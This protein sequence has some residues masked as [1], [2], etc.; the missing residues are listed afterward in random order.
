MSGC[1]PSEEN[2]RANCTC[3]CH[4]KKEDWNGTACCKCHVHKFYAHTDILKEEYKN[5]QLLLENIDILKNELRD[6]K[7]VYLE[8]HV[9]QIDENR[10]ISRRVD[11]LQS[12]INIEEIKKVIFNGL[13]THAS[14]LRCEARNK[15]L[16]KEINEISK[17]RKDIKILTDQSKKPHECPVCDGMRK[18]KVFGKNIEADCPACEGKGI[19]W[20]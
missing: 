16:E 3:K 12:L 10:K 8:E 4:R 7:S 15:E 18:F 19:V 17:W 1:F 20:G 5:H 6:L 2:I 14:I 11:E 9:R 13:E